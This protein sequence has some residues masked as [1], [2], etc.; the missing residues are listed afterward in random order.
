MNPL[1]IALRGGWSSW[2]EGGDDL[3][4]HNVTLFEIVT[5]NPP[6]QQIYPNKNEGKTN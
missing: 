6:V 3:T 4:I 2:G 1:I 5:M